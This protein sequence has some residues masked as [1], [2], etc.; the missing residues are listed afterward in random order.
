ML[1]ES[2]IGPHIRKIRKSKKLTLDELADK[3]RISKGYLSKLENSDK[4]PPVST[5]INIAKGLDITISDIFGESKENKSFSLVKKNERQFMAHNGT[6]FGYSYETLA[7]NYPNKKMEPYI[8]TI[9]AQNSNMGLFQ[10]NGEEMLMVL[11]GKFTFRHGE[12]EYSLEEGDCV[13]FD[14]GIPHQ[15]VLPVEKEVK[16]L[17]V[18][19]TP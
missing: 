3:C 15:P 19:F 5:L 13:Y 9:P 12:E 17:I 7:H 4:A 2:D 10:H 8:L 18:I 11:K 6:I 14:S 1:P 16:C